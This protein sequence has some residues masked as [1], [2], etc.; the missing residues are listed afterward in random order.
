MRPLGPL[1]VA[2]LSVGCMWGLHLDVSARTSRLCAPPSPL[3][4]ALRTRAAPALPFLWG[5]FAPSTGMLRLGSTLAVR[6]PSNLSRFQ[7]SLTLMSF[8]VICRG[9]R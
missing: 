7:E 1:T 5:S 3:F 9:Q 8:H 6:H 4:F 2:V